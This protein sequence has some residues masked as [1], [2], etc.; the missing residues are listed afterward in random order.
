[1]GGDVVV[2]VCIVFGLFCFVVVVVCFV[3][4]IY[5]FVW[6]FVFYIIVS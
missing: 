1:M 6:G 5:C 3:V 2:K 4:L